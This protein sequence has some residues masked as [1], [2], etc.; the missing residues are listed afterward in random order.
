MEGRRTVDVDEYDLQEKGQRT[1]A[2]AVARFEFRYSLSKNVSKLYHRSLFDVK[3]EKYCS[4]NGGQTDI[5]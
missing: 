3:K 5:G 1:E 4:R 2:W